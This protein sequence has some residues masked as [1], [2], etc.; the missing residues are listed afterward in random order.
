MT[1][2]PGSDTNSAAPTSAP[3]IVSTIPAASAAANTPACVDRAA[4]VARTAAFVVIA[5]VLTLSATACGSFAG[6][7]DPTAELASNQ[8]VAAPAAEESADTASTSSTAGSTST[9]AEGVADMYSRS[10]TRA[11]VTADSLVIRDSPNGTVTD[12]MAAAT[13]YGTTRV[14][15]VQQLDGD[16]V[17]V[18]LPSRPNHRTGWV[19]ASDVE[20]QSLSAEVRVN[21][22]TR[23]LTVVTGDEV[24]AQVEVAIGSVENPTPKGT[25]YVTDK[26][27]TSSD[28][29]AY[30]PYALGLSGYSETLSEFGGGDG[31]I[32][33]HGTNEPDSLGQAVSH[34][35]V[36][37]PNELITWMAQNLPLG[38]PVHI[39]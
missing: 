19:S 26:L 15:L 20:L 22:E 29:S 28:D 38:T 21:L 16:W 30:G 2:D 11:V 33:I 36:R 4:R 10:T 24:L 5:L 17:Q 3:H 37:L 25:F 23:L 39:V 14:L 35:C 8:V 13:E 12:T 34:G 18:R 27:E 7:Q 32:G 6:G 31:Q 9:R 1:R